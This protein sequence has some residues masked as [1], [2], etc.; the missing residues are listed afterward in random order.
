MISVCLATYNGARHVL[1]QLQSV[2][3]QLS[4]DDEL[5]VSD[6]GSTDATREVVKGTGDSR[7]VLIDGPRA[8]L[9]R[10]FEH[11]LRQARGDVIFLCDQDDIWLAGKVQ[12]VMQALEGADLVVTDC[13]V[14]DD[15]LQELHPSFFRLNGSRAG[16]LRNLAKNGYLGCCMAMR[17]TVLEDALPFPGNIAMHDWWIGL[18]AERTARVRFLDEVLSLY[19]RHG[20]NAS[21]AATRSTVSLATR[22]RWRLDMARDLV[23]RGRQRRAS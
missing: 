4:A 19:R 8:G 13:R 18:V 1:A 9:V 20:N 12:R 3:P 5:I 15:A 14:V 22:L 2:L 7:I 6:D 21:P 11:A 17:R 23:A 16:L 10:N